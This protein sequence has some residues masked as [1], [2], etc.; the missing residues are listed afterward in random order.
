MKHSQTIGILLCLALIYTTTQPFIIIESRHWVITGWNPVGSSFGQSGKFL[1]FFAA[2]G[3][4][5]F[6]LPFIWAKRFN[7]VFGAFLFAW[8]F[9]NYLNSI[10]LSNG[11]VSTKAMGIVWMYY[12][13]RANFINDIFTQ[14]KSQLVKSIS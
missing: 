11:G 14:N 12:F 6:A 7:M 1:C 2:L 9:R 4:L 3:A 5:F 13:I 8:S 10:Y